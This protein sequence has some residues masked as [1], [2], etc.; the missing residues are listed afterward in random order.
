MVPLRAISFVIPDLQLLNYRDQL[1][2]DAYQRPPLWLALTYAPVYAG[3]WLAAAR[4]LL[5]R[6]EF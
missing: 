3:I 1:R 6:K 2:A 4:A 5:Q